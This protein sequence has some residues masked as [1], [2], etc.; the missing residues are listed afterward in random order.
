MAWLPERKFFYSDYSLKETTTYVSTYVQNTSM[1]LKA[2]DEKDESNLVILEKVIKPKQK[3]YDIRLGIFR[4]IQTC[5]FKLRP[6]AFHIKWQAMDE[7]DAL[8]RCYIH[9][10]PITP[11]STILYSKCCNVQLGTYVLSKTMNGKRWTPSC[12]ILKG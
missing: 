8:N 7:K 5:I 6:P 1:Q 10:E 9:R 4:Y 12:Y 11:R 3:R 2:I